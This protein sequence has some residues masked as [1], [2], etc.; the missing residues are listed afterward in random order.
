MPLHLH[1]RLTHSG[2]P[3]DAAGSGPVNVPVVR[4]STVRFESMAAL[5][6]QARRRAEGEPTSTYGRQ[7]METHRALEA[8]LCE[9]EGGVQAF[10]APSGLAAISLSLLALVGPGD[11]VLVT[12]GVYHPVRKLHAEYLDR[13]GVQMSYFDPAAGAPEAHLRPNTR[14]VYVETPNSLLYQ[15]TDLGP[16]VALCR[17]RGISV[18]ADNTWA[19]GYLFNPLAH[20]AD[21]SVIAGTKY[22]SG[23]SDLMMGMIVV[24]DAAHAKRVQKTYEA[25]GM[26]VGPDDAYLALRGLRTLAVR[27]RQHEA[28]ALAVANWLAAR[29]EVARVYYPALPSHPGHDLWRRDFRGANGLLSVA[30]AG[31]G[32]A[33]ALA[34]ADRLKLFDIGASWG[35]YESLVLP[36]DANR[37]AGPPDAQDDATPPPML[38]LHIGLE[39]P[40]DLIA[41]L[42][43]AIASALAM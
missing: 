4:T 20:G 9:L 38:R 23:H 37:L 24:R 11:H 28:N 26:A 10:L 16:I 22:I 15:L 12:E 8:A 5:R 1:T 7:G 21:V 39:Q 2:R 25:L 35:G 43:Q 14:V 18:V 19:S 31:L 42:G 41:D 40:E 17:E 6:E 30:F 36:I 33:Q 32:E 13:I 3:A 27:L 34:V 29:P